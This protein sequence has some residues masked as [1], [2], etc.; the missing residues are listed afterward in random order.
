MNN[1][2]WHLGAVQLG[3]GEFGTWQETAQSNEVLD[4]DIH[5]NNQA[6]PT[7]E[8]NGVRLLTWNQI[9]SSPHK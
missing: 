1:L 7:D 4:T 2:M 3:E 9:L 8:M 6:A 5:M